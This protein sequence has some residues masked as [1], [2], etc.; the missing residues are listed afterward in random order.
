MTEVTDDGDRMTPALVRAKQVCGAEAGCAEET[1]LGADVPSALLAN[2]R[3][4]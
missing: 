1:S 4:Q 3:H 2:G